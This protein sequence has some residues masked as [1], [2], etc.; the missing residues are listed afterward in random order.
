M[1]LLSLLWLAAGFAGVI[2]TILHKD[3]H[4]TAR[5]LLQAVSLAPLGP[6]ALCFLLAHI[7]DRHPARCWTGSCSTCGRSAREHHSCAGSS[8]RHVGQHPC[9]WRARLWDHQG[10]T[11]QSSQ[12][13]ARRLDP[14]RLRV[15]CDV[16]A[17]HQV[18]APFLPEAGLLCGEEAQATHRGTAGRRGVAAIRAAAGILRRLSCR[19][20]GGRERGAMRPPAPPHE[21]AILRRAGAGAPG[22]RPLPLGADMT[23]EQI[24][25]LADRAGGCRELSRLSG[26]DRRL[27]QRQCKG[28]PPQPHHIE[29]LEAAQ[30]QITQS[31]AAALASAFGRIAA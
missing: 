14:M 22:A 1:I 17:R 6:G 3:G 20:A 21:H 5:D 31:H 26:I 2:G 29:R 4:L 24:I 28:Q 18:R 13:Q 19:R 25:T 8:A 10:R 9:P 12:D 30:R 27:L 7:A 11:A 15:R 16:Q 23:P